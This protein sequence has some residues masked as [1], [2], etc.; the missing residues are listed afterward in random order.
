[1]GCL[2]FPA[3]G[4]RVVDAEGAAWELRLR[5]ASSLAE[6]SSSVPEAE[7]WA[8]AAAAAAAAAVGADVADVAGGGVAMVDAVDATL[9]ADAAAVAVIMVAA[10]V[11]VGRGIARTAGA[12]VDN[13]CHCVVAAA[14][15]IAEPHPGGDF[16][17]TPPTPASSIVECDRPDTVVD[18]AACERRP[19]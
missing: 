10:A 13:T 8:D 18:A 1:M 11:V 14:E 19:S 15:N 4:R 16:V 2:S 9:A 17:R 12:V 7:V 5:G 3:I 6:R